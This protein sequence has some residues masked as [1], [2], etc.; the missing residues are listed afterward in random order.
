MHGKQRGRSRTTCALGAQLAR[1][2]GSQISCL[3]RVR[4]PCR[5]ELHRILGENALTVGRVQRPLTIAQSLATVDRGPN[6]S[7][8]E[9][10]H[11]RLIEQ[12]KCPLAAASASQF[13]D[14]IPTMP[15]AIASLSLSFGLVSIPV[16][17]YSATEASSA[18]RFKLMRA[19]GAR[20]RQ[21]YVSDEPMDECL[22]HVRHSLLAVGPRPIVHEAST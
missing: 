10:R 5:S 2:W 18:V 9:G 12:P 7:Y 19:D 22:Q 21:Q 14:W 3:D 8:R 13:A 6:A 4:R 20:V 11:L 15:R 16:K 1:P 17:L